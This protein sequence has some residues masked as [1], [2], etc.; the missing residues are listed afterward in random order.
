M[1]RIPE[2]DGELGLK[3]VAHMERLTWE[4]HG[5]LALENARRNSELLHHGQSLVELRDVPIGTGNHAIVIAAGPSIKRCDPA[6]LIRESGY[7][8][9]VIATES[10]TAYCLRCGIVPNLV[11]TIDPHT[12]RV[13]RWLGDPDLTKEGLSADDYFSRQDQDD[14]FADEMRANEEILRLL[15]RHGS[16]IRIALSTTASEAVV[17]RVLET[18]MRIYWW[19]PMLDDP[20]DPG[21]VTAELQKEN[22]LPC[23]NAGGNV[24]SACWMMA[25]EVL[26]KMHVALVGMDFSYYDETPYFNTQYYHEAVALVG[27]EN[28]DAV[29]M[30]IHNPYLDAWFYTDPAYMWYRECL[31]EMAAD[32]HC[33]TYNCTEGGILF[34]EG[35]EFIPLAEFLDRFAAGSAV[36]AAGSPAS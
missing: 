36:R 26:G 24:G 22:G 6:R 27:E 3:L 33:Q 34:G 20:D 16:D 13:V 11:V 30:R 17:N 29:Y 5:R 25:S 31:L 14:A 15:D 9:A 1:T 7:D 18:G 28:L 8:G 19:N 2:R 32:A 21:S 23:V 35:I 12:T 4:R 10:A